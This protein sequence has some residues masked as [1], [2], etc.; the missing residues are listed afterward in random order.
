MSSLSLNTL[1]HK[2]ALRNGLRVIT[3][4][5]PGMRSCAVG[6]WI[7]AGSEDEPGELNGISHFIEHMVFKG[8]KRRSTRR[9]AQYLESVG[10]YLNAFTTK[11]HT[12]Y[13]ARV[14]DVHLRRALDILADIVC[15]SRFPAGEIGKE[16]QVIVEEMKSLEDEPEEMLHDHFEQHL[17]SPH[18]LGR[19]VIGTEATVRAL[20][21]SDLLAY[22]RSHYAKSNMLVVGVGNVAHDSFLREVERSF[23][24]APEGKL[25]KRRRKPPEHR[26]FLERLQKPISQ[27]HLCF[28]TLVP[29]AHSPE[30]YALALV[31]T[32]LGDG[33]SSRLFQSVRERHALA[34][35]IYSFLSLFDEAGIFGI[36]VATDAAQGHRCLHL[37]GEELRR[38]ESRGISPREL[39]RTKE[40]MKGNFLLGLEST[41]NRMTAIARNEL[42][43]GRHETPEDVLRAID[44][45]TLDEAAEAIARLTA[46]ETFS[47]MVIEPEKQ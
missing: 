31:N 32:L 34:Y 47:T 39:R 44:R 26:R 35:S 6:I 14:R 29:D 45:V 19:L 5:V 43:Y 33:M 25:R 37:I 18:P 42:Y 7:D 9:I 46:M 15:N 38:L 40:Q 21:R 23:A 20:R 13:Y 41:T 30:R 3:E 1:F 16:K 11:E 27:T 4:A 10:G 36:Y 8:T 2:S 24:N 22:A 12:C 28:G 17:L